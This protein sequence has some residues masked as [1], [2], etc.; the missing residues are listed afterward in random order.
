MQ[1][2]ITNALLLV[3]ASGV[4]YLVAQ[5]RPHWFRFREMR[6]SFLSGMIVAL[7]LAASLRTAALVYGPTAML[8]VISVLGGLILG[9]W[10]GQRTPRTHR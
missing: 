9:I 3:I 8:S 7:L 10:L 2:V 5:G 1:I 6:G 4:G